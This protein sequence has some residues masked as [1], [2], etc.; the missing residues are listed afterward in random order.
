MAEPD[1]ESIAQSGLEALQRGDAAA[2]RLAFGQVAEAGRASLQLRLFLAQA[3][4]AIGDDDAMIAALAPVLQHEPRNVGALLMHAELEVRR[5][6]DRAADSWFGM[7]LSS[8]SGHQSLPADLV[9]KLKRAE[10]WTSQS[11]KRFSAHLTAQLALNGI[12]SNKT[13]PRFAEAMDILEGRAQPQLQQPTSFYYP[14][15]PQIPFYDSADFEWVAALEASV[16]AIKSEAAAVLAS[17]I[18]L[19]P[20]VEADPTRP[21]KAHKLLGSEDWTAFHLWRNGVVVS[22]NAARC[23]ATMTA[24]ENLPMPRI[25]DR[26]PMALFSVLK[27]KTHIPPHWGMINTRLICHIPLIVP[28]HCRLR[29]GNETRPVESGKAMI[30]D[31]SIE[32]EA[33][34]DSDETRVVLLLEIW[35]PELDATERRALTTMFEAIGNY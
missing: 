12:D 11:A 15:L 29:I 18:G 19:G 33:W 3:C 26:S 32:H 27:P 21:N 23:P 30:F 13:S 28:E 22:D 6:D 4:E 5:G 10:L 1:Y 24:L 34:N 31:D 14:R 25:N 9:A 20:Y 16:P 8:A 7:A 35:R 2:A 17:G